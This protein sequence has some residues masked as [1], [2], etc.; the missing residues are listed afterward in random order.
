M[1]AKKKEPKKLT[2]RDRKRAQ[3][4]AALYFSEAERQAI[5]ET[6]ASD[7][8]PAQ[9]KIYFYQCQALGLNPLLNEITA[10]N[11]T[12]K[13]GTKRMSIQVMRDGFLTIAHRSGKFAGMESGVKL[14][15]SNK[16]AV[17]DTQRLIGWARVYHKN[18][19]KPLY[20][21][22]DFAEYDNSKRNS[23]WNSKPKTMIKKVAESMALRKAFN[24]SGV[25]AAEEMEREIA[26]TK[27]PKAIQLEN[28]D[29][30]ASAEQIGTLVALTKNK[31][32]DELPEALQKLNKPKANQKISLSRQEAAEFIS[33]FSVKKK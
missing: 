9:V 14:D 4:N 5:V 23:L 1:A 20:Q 19:K 15:E 24:V 27:A 3:P 18:F 13:N 25:Y 28:P 11:Y 26:K 33:E 30:P 8:E 17:S 16:K 21:E 7:L 2:L 22:A 32:Q 12:M 29:A 31:E 6:V 10:I